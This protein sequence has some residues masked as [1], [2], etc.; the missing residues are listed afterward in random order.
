MHGISAGGWVYK[1]K[2]IKDGYKE[3]SCSDHGID[4]RIACETCQEMYMHFSDKLKELSENA[5]DHENK[6][7]PTLNDTIIED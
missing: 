1:M 3:F 5:I 4:Y 7:V 2:N 6:S